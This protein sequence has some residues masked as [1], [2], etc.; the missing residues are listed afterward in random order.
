MEIRKILIEFVIL[1]IVTLVVNAI[2]IYV[3]KGAFD[4][5]LSF[6]LAIAIGIGLPL[7]HALESKD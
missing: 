6:S 4:W 1:F 2:V 5:G 7:A 3:W